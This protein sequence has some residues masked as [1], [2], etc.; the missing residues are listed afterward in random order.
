MDASASPLVPIHS[1]SC[2][3]LKVSRTFPPDLLYMPLSGTLGSGSLR[4][5][6][7]GSKSSGFPC[8]SNTVLCGCKSQ[9]FV[10]TA[11]PEVSQPEQHPHAQT[12][13][14]ALHTPNVVFHFTLSNLQHIQL[15]LLG[16][17]GVLDTPPVGHV[18]PC[19]KN[20]I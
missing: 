6:T 20:G 8:F 12:T 5:F 1:W 7:P 11:K 16:G 18:G 13:R 19:L 9:K 2:S 10:M 17:S 4:F 3:S 14:S 15:K